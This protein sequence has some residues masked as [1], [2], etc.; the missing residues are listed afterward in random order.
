[1]IYL[2]GLQINTLITRV[3]V[4]LGGV[5]VVVMT[6]ERRTTRDSKRTHGTNPEASPA[7]SHGLVSDQMDADGPAQGQEG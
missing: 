1:M 4:F 3:D 6:D 5:F 7:A 2:K